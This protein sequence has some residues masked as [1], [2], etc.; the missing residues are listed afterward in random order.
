MFVRSEYSGARAVLDRAI[1]DARAAGIL[2]RRLLGH[3][4]PFDVSVFPG[5][6]SY[7]CGEETA[8]LNA[9][10]GRRGEVRLRPPYPVES[11][12]YGRP[13]VVNNVET[14]VNV[15]WIVA[16]GPEAYRTLGTAASA[17]TKASA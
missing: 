15:P 11:G 17:G 5:L 6:G 7:V 9:I 8:L 4:P 16:N 1:D 12:L 3:G 14:L 13:T 10:E 2:G